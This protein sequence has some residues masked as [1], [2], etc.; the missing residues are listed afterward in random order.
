[1]SNASSSGKNGTRIFESTTNDD[2]HVSF[3]KSSDD[4]HVSFSKNGIEIDFD[5]ELDQQSNSQFNMM[6][7]H[8]TVPPMIDYAA[9]KTRR[10]NSLTTGGIRLN[11]AFCSSG[12]TSST[13]NLSHMMH[14]QRSFSLSIENPRLL[15]TTSGSETRLD[16]LKPT[17]QTFHTQHTGMSYVGAWLK[18]LRLHKYAWVFEK[19]TYEQMMDITEEYLIQLVV[20]KGA[21]HKLL[22]CIQKLKERYNSLAQAEKDLTNGKVTTSA[23][24]DMLTEVVATPMKP[25][26]K[27][28]TVDVGAQFLKVLHLGKR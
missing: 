10:S 23:V 16:D 25:I 3:S 6:C 24:V 22:N 8:L 18:R 5:P 11:D 9:L 2:H 12:F 21:R 7:D 28:N 19:F 17:Y 1:M 20:T 14:K 13:E 4:H 27:Y 26:E 15:M